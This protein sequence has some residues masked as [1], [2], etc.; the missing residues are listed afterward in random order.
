M[1][2]GL[3][4][5]TM[6]ALCLG[7]LATSTAFTRHEAVKPTK[8]IWVEN[9]CE[10]NID[11][12]YLSPVEESTWGD[13]L[14]DPDEVLEPGE[15]VEIEIDCGEWD[16]KLVAPDGSTCEVKAVDICAADIW[17]VVAECP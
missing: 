12:I 5:F 14:L 1:T 16:V 13:D 2:S 11:M 10:F 6:A 9:K 4:R 7:V 8:S 17:Q 3:K 15:K